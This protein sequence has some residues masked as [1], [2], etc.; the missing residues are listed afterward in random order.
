[1]TSSPRQA[2]PSY[3]P[4]YEAGGS[5]PDFY[6]PPAKNNAG[7]NIVKILRN[8]SALPARLRGTVR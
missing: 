5:D 6:L 1:M 4:V 8:I 7:S 3:S 2:P